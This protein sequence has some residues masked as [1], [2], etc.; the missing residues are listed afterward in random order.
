MKVAVGPK[1]SVHAVLNGQLRASF[2]LRKTRMRLA[3]VV[4]GMRTHPSG[5]MTQLQKT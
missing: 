2:K 4:H 3:V 1:R 5:A